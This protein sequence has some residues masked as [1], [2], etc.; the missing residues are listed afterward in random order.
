MART[1]KI[2]DEE[3]FAMLVDKQF[4]INGITDMSYAK[5]LENK[6]V[7]DTMPPGEAWYQR[8]KTTQD[9]EEEFKN[10]LKYQYKKRYKLRDKALETQAGLFLLAYGLSRSDYPW[11][12]DKDKEEK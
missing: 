9:K 6:E 4:E 5:L 12:V 1:K 2:S 7:E 8:Y 11:A 10:F 3:F